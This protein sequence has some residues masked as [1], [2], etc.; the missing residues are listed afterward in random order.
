MHVEKKLMMTITFLSPIT[1]G[2]QKRQSLP[3][4]YLQVIVKPLDGKS[5]DVQLYTD[6]SAGKT[7]PSFLRCPLICPRMGIWRPFECRGMGVQYYQRRNSV[8]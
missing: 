3:F 1:P 8:P 7:L 2:D 4:S 5:H 6:I